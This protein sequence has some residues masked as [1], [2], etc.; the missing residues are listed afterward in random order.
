MDHAH[1]NM[2]VIN[3][4]GGL[5]W[6]TAHANMDDIYITGGLQRFTTH[7]NMDV[8][9]LTGGLQWIMHML[10]VTLHTQLEII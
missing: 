6:Y 4:T 8:I 10:V 7:C 2:D 1:G 9:Y 5:Q 3:I